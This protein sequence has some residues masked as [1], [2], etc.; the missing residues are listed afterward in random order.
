MQRL[1]FTLSLFAILLLS[2]TST[3]AQLINPTNSDSIAGH[4][5]VYD[6]NNNLKS[7]YKP[8]LPG[9]GYDHI[10]KLASEFIKD[11]VPVEPK[12]GEKMYFVTC[13]FQGPHMHD[14]VNAPNGLV[15]EDWMH[16][17]ACFFAGAVIGLAK[18][19]RI[20]SGDD[21]YLEVVGEMLDYQLQNGTTPDDWLWASV[22]YA[23]SDP[24]EKIYRG[25]QRW[26]SEG[27]RGDGLNG[28][29]PDKVGE[30]IRRVEDAF[31]RQLWPAA[32]DSGAEVVLHGNHFST[33]MTPPD[34]FDTYF[35]PY[36]AE[37][38]ALMHEHGKKVM[39]HADAE[40]G[41]LFQRVVDAGF[42]AADCLATTPL[43]PQ[44]MSHYFDAWEGRVVCWG[45]LPGTIFDPHY[46]MDAFRGCV[47]DL[48]ELTR[49]RSDFIF[50][51]SDQVMPGAEWKRLRYVAEVTG[52]MR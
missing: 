42:D 1:F 20:Y 9:A 47:D 43:V 18:G 6:E 26:E 4:R 49:G 10:I 24:F 17:P 15:A 22:P 36:F 27:M 29:E 13:C 28:I 40:M 19:Y 31:R 33:Q 23:S 14:D 8:E 2:T 37:F 46:P 11:G 16:N 51:A 45:G 5:A 32:R 21:G 3:S 30:L 50:G 52:C 41:G 34:I 25:A 39:F 35:L 38:N 7:W 48:V 44:S 12:T